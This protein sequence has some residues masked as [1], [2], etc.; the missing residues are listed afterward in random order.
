VSLCSTRDETRY[1]H[2]FKITKTNK[3]KKQMTTFSVTSAT[4]NGLGDTQGTLSY[5]IL[6]ANQL[7]GDDTISMNTDVRVTGVMKTLVNSNITIVGNNH[8]LSGDVNNNGSNDS[9]DVRPLFILSGS[10]N[11]SDLSITNGRA[12]G[13]SGGGGGGGL[14]GGL[15]IYDG[16]VSLTNVAFTNNIAQGGLAT[17]AAAAAAECLAMVQVAAAD[18]LAML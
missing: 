4:D 14:G 3:D 13:G 1:R 6:Q 2:K 10:V 17:A 7:P 18:C 11:I 5:A 15:F 8:S 16:N 12:Q 9:G